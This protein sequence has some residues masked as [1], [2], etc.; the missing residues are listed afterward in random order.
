M[1][2]T[3]VIILVIAVVILV[4]TTYVFY[5]GKKFLE[6]SGLMEPARPA[7][8]ATAKAKAAVEKEDVCSLLP[9]KELA[10]ATGV[11]ILRGVPH[12]VQR[13]QAGCLYVAK[14][15]STPPKPA[16]SLS[17]LLDWMPSEKSVNVD[18]KNVE[19][20]ILSMKQK[21]TEAARLKEGEAILL[22]TSLI[23]ERANVRLK[24]LKMLRAILPLGSQGKEEVEALGNTEPLPGLGDEAYFSPAAQE[25]YVIHGGSFLSIDLN[26]LPDARNKGL[27]LARTVLP[28][29]LD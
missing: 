3:L 19:K 20:Q 15:P 18:A 24:M 1:S 23:V 2:R 7:V 29:L 5:K 8:P 14:A 13:G 21:E 9:P 27:A 16:I 17:R 11:P 26:A 28:R 6:E 4:P 22:T 25:L 10:Q 12:S